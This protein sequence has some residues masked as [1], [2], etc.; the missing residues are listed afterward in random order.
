MKRMRIVVVVL[1]LVALAGSASAQ[2][3][4]GWSQTDIGGPSPAGNASYD[5]VTGTWTVTSD[6][7]DIWDTWD[8]FHFVFRSL[9]GDGMMTARVVSIAGAGL[10]EW[11]KAGVMIRETLNANSRH[12]M[13]TMTPSGIQNHAAQF[14][15]RPTTGGFS[16]QSSGGSMNLPYWVRIQRTGN[17]FRGYISPNG[18]TWTQQG[19]AQTISMSQNVYIGLVAVSHVAGQLN[20][21]KFDNVAI[22]GELIEEV[23][24]KAITYQGRLLD[25]DIAADGLYDLQFS[26]L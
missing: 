16:D 14:L 5:Q 13:M 25:G 7:A 26:L 23:P 11:A 22:Q 4:T 19:T 21:D 18:S 2:L 10:H 9:K 3:P 24:A 20:T 1:A 8:S 6:G 12:A 17:T 15:W